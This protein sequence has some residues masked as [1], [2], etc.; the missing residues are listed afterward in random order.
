VING[1][2][3]FE[4]TLEPREVIEAF[5]SQ[6]VLVPDWESRLLAA[7]TGLMNV[8]PQSEDQVLTDLG[9]RLQDL[10]RIGIERD[11]RTRQASADIESLL[12]SMEISTDGPF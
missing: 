6:G 8:G 4:P 7:S 9:G 2:L 1:T 12:E 3:I 10:V 11:E 5:L